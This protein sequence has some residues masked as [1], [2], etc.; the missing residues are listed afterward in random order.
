MR[1]IDFKTCIRNN[2]QKGDD[3]EGGNVG[4][5]RPIGE[6]ASSGG[7]SRQIRQGRHAWGRRGRQTAVGGGDNIDGGG[8]GWW[9]RRQR[10]GEMADASRGVRVFGRERGRRGQERRG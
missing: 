7:R 8:G 6:E 9:G 2:V 3:G 5:R 10:A 1:C 4:Q